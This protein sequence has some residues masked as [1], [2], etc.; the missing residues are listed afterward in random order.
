MDKKNVWSSYSKKQLTE[1]EKLNKEYRHFLDHGKTERECIREA[2]KLAKE[3][4]Y[5]D[6]G[7]VIRKKETLSEGDKVYAVCMGK[8][9][10]LF[11]I[12]SKD[13]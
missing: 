12:G 7:E 5:R 11:H 4:G 3:A 9:I 8:T 10:A 6:L 1:L 2:V 13:I